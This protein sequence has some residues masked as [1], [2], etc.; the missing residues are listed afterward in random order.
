MRDHVDGIVALDDCSTD[1][2]VDILKKEPRI[3][4]ILREN[5]EAPP[6]F[7]ES[8]N[9]YRLLSE[10]AR[11]GA[12]WVICADADERYEERFLR[13]LPKEAARGEQSGHY[14]RLVKIKN[15]WN[16]HRLYRSDGIN[17][18]RWTARMFKV[19]KQFTCREGA[20]HL[21]WF[22]PE[23]DEAPRQTM[24]ANLYHLRM[25]ERS[26]RK[27]RY[28]KFKAIDPDHLHQNIGYEH[29]VDETDIT[30]RPVLPWRGFRGVSARE[31]PWETIKVFA[32]TR[33]KQQTLTCEPADNVEFDEKYYLNEYD[34]V[35]AAVTRGE[36]ANGWEHFQSFGAKE[37]RQSHR[38]N[39][40]KIKGLDIESIFF[41]IQK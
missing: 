6:H 10:A 22:P 2:T 24:N 30:L 37:G 34:D 8:K 21:P 20:M 15:L 17:G 26:A 4:S 31:S 36:F 35:R 3:I 5:T 11:L 38:S 33:N 41:D 28:G 40:A 19:P 18:P 29:L 25:I 27:K 14:V 39:V 12:E 16:S 9:R 13:K 32:E 7:N 23:L 1:A